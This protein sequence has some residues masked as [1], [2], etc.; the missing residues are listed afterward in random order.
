MEPDP[1]GSEGGATV[2]PGRMDLT[3]FEQEALKE[4]CSQGAQ[5]AADALGKLLGWRVSTAFRQAQVVPQEDA[6]ARWKRSGLRTEGS[7]VAAYSRVPGPIPLATLVTLDDLSALSAVATLR[8]EDDSEI[9]PLTFEDQA[10]LKE[11]CNILG[12]SFLSVLAD[13]LEV[14]LLPRSPILITDSLAAI[15]DFVAL[16][17]SSTRYLLTFS[18]G[19]NT[20]RTSSQVLIALILDEAALSALATKIDRIFGLEPMLAV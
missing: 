15:I 7:L 11:F 2:S 18:I 9:R 14:P 19:L 8:G 1:D 5:R 10:M 12:N 16:S 3:I 17:Q 6:L 13:L 4:F 20:Q